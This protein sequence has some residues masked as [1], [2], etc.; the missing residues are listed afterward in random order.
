MDTSM[1]RERVRVGGVPIDRVTMNEALYAIGRLVEARKGGAVFTPNVDHVVEYEENP[2]LREAYEA[3]SLS[4]AD[5]MPV[6]WAS[7]VMGAPLP[8]RVAGSDLLM[9]LARRAADRGWRVFLLGGAEG[10]AER[11]KAELERL[12]PGIQITGTLAPRVDMREPFE[13]RAAIRDVLTKAAPDLVVVAFGA[14]KQE[15]FIHES[16]AA[17]APAVLLGLGASLDFVAG[18]V[19]RA[20]RWMAQNGLEWAYRLAREPTRLWRRYLVRDPKFLMILL[21][22]RAR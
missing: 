8:E 13:A 3:A 19:P 10:V 6:V 21:R 12:V 4:L 9:P 5:G 15:L 16:R 17:L 20:P 7:R 1:D 11:A 14:P 18:A 22:R 2:R